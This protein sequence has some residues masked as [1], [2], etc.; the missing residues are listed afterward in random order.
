MRLWVG[1]GWFANCCNCCCCCLSYMP[2]R[3]FS[4]LPGTIPCRPCS[5]QSHQPSKPCVSRS[6]TV[7]M[8]PFR[9]DNSSGDSATLSYRAFANTFC[10]TE[11]RERLSL[12]F[13][14]E[15]YKARYLYFAV[16]PKQLDCDWNHPHSFHLLACMLQY[17]DL[18]IQ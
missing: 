7:M 18:F 6:R 10:K 16:T 13:K 12:C 9:K 8:S 11:K 4:R 17:K 1:L 15:A 14:N 5:E 2:T 3:I